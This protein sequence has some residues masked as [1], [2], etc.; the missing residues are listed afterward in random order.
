MPLRK[1]WIDQWELKQ[2]SGVEVMNLEEDAAA[3][4]AGV[5]IE[6]VIIGLGDQPATSV[7]D[8]H[9]L[10]TQ[11]PVGIPTPVT[12]LHSSHP[13]PKPKKYLIAA[14]KLK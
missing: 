14:Q 2:S 11:L 4:M 10:L 12:L 5:W 13:S 3:Q 9:R 1:E 8:L 6:D 7:D